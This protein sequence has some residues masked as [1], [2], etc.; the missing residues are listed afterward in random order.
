MGATFSIKVRTEGSSHQ[1]VYKGKDGKAV[2]N[3]MIGAIENKVLDLTGRMVAQKGL[4]ASERTLWYAAIYFQR[5]ISRT[6]RDED[7]SYRD[8]KK[9]IHYHKADDDYIQDY[10]TARYWNYEG[11]T[12]KYL[13]ESCGCTFEVF[14]NPKEIEVIYREFRG[15][16]FGAAGSR[17]RANKESGKTTLKSVRFYCDYP[18][19]EEHELRYHLLEYGGYIGDGIIK[20]SKGNKRYHGVANGHSIQAAKGMA[21]MT[22]AEFKSGQFEVPGKSINTKKLLE[23]IGATQNMTAEIKNILKRKKRLSDSDVAKIMSLYGV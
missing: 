16:F 9:H 14:N 3:L 10:W 19:D 12:A 21:A 11:I 23:H 13:R 18:K 1:K 5:L 6:P 20:K 8:S 2:A 7:Y 22:D 15:R 17:G 4:E